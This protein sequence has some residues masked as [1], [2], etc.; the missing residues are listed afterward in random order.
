MD[1]Y[2]GRHERDSGDPVFFEVLTGVARK[3]FDF[4]KEDII[5]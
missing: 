3:R 4:L 5:S 1:T 2:D